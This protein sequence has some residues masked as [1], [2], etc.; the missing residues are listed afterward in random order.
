MSSVNCALS[1]GPTGADRDRFKCRCQ[2]AQAVLSP[3]CITVVYRVACRNRVWRKGPPKFWAEAPPRTL[4]RNP[5]SP[6]N[7]KSANRLRGEQNCHRDWH[8]VCG[9]RRRPKNKLPLNQEE[10]G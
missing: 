9:V 1:I 3:T 4:P 10:S 6:K 7:I 8:V 2:A 5:A